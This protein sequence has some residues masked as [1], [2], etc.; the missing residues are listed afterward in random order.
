MLCYSLLHSKVNQL[1]IHRLT[2]PLFFRSFSRY[3]SSTRRTGGA[4]LRPE[5]GT[6]L[7]TRSYSFPL[8]MMKKTGLFSFLA[9]L[10]GALLEAEP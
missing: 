4:E 5:P 2:Y 9:H 8:K 7:F 10:Y 6:N 3:R 1:H